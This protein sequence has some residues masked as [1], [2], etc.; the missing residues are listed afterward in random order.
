MIVLYS[1]KS[2]FVLLLCWLIG[3]SYVYVQITGER[4]LWLAKAGEGVLDRPQQ[5]RLGQMPELPEP[6]PP[7]EPEPAQPVADP[8]LNRGLALRVNQGVG[9]QTDTLILELDYVAAQTDGF[10]IEKVRS[11]YLAD[12]P[13]FVVALGAPWASDIENTSFSN[14]M[15]QVTRLNLIVSESQNL[16]LLVHTRSMSIAQ[17]AR[18][19]TSSTD[20]GIRAEIRLPR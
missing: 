6:A 13:T 17:G 2:Q 10:T 8:T 1:R 16:R 3:M 11:Y 20:T 19:R 5:A 12:S 18:L 7:S 4:P 9:E 15:P 14:L